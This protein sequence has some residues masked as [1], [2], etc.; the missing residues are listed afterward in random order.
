MILEMVS[1]DLMGIDL[2][3]DEDERMSCIGQDNLEILI[4]CKFLYF[5]VFSGRLACLESEGREGFVGALSEVE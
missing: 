1:R 2:I 4:I 3:E 5:L